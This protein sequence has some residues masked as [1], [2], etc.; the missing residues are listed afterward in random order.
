MHRKRLV[1]IEC[2]VLSLLRNINI[3]S[4]SLLRDVTIKRSTNCAFVNTDIFGNFALIHISTNER[5]NPKPLLW[6]K[7][8][9][10][11]CHVVTMVVFSAPPD[12]G[13]AK[14][15]PNGESSPIHL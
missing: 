1:I 12:R 6:G 10:L 14:R 2:F 5:F 3:R 15:S 4:C 11:L 9:K 7:L 13:V 8:F